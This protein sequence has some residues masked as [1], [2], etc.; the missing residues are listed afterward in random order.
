MSETDSFIDEVTEEVRRDRMAAMMRKYGWIAFLIIALIVG[1]AAFNE[2][3]KSRDAAAAQAFGDAILAAQGQPDRLAALDGLAAQAD[4][5]AQ[6]KALV[7][8]MAADAALI[9]GDRAGAKTRLEQMAGDATLPGSLRDMLRLK[10]V[11]LADPTADPALTD[12]ALTELAAPGAPYR[13]L[14]LEQKAAALAAAGRG[15]EAVSLYRQILAEPELTAGLRRRVGEIMVTLGAD[16]EAE[17][18]APAMQ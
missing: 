4:L 5:S 15:D 9:A 10:V 12:A 8:M 6:Q 11:L 18:L 2:W 17:A 16:P 13:T 1:G 7:T 3:R 14:A